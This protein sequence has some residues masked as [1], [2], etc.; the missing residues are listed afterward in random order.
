MRRWDYQ[1]KLVK[2]R[3]DYLAKSIDNQLREDGTVKQNQLRENGTTK[4][5]QQIISLLWTILNNDMFFS[6]IYTI[7]TNINQTK[8]FAIFN[9]TKT[10][11]NHL[12]STYLEP[13][14]FMKIHIALD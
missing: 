4:K 3:W 10:I 5:N 14:H 1:T 12:I 9:V 11:S 6:K 2:R 13:N 7:E 8:L